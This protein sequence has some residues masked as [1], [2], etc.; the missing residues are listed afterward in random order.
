MWR[1]AFSDVPTSDLPHL[2][3]I[4][5][6]WLMIRLREFIDKTKNTKL[7][8]IRNSHMVCFH[9]QTL[10]EN[11][12]CSNLK[13]AVNLFRSKSVS[14]VHRNH[15]LTVCPGQRSNYWL[16]EIK[17]KCLLFFFFF[18]NHDFGLV[19]I[20]MFFLWQF[21]SWMSP[22]FWK[23]SSSFWVTSSPHWFPQ[24]LPS[25]AVPMVTIWPITVKAAVSPCF[26]FSQCVS[27]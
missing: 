15:R 27:L 2:H 25:L 1:V 20:S 22:D 21:C 4:G 14:A 24:H 23:E 11:R 18:I 7:Q 16:T 3:D 26:L 10:D 5:E 12:F 19:I 13:K 6:Q 9:L 8:K 17:T